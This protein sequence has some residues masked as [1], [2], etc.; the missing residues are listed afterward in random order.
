LKD[1]EID[2]NG[3]GREQQLLNFDNNSPIILAFMSLL[4]AILSYFA[5]R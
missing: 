3:D 5:Q 2:G 4:I 1:Y